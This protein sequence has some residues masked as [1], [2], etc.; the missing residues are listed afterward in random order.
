MDNAVYFFNSIAAIPMSIPPESCPHLFHYFF[1]LLSQPTQLMMDIKRR[2]EG[3]YSIMPNVAILGQEAKVS[4]SSSKRVFIPTIFIQADWVCRNHS[5]GPITSF[6]TV[7]L[8]RS[9]WK[10]SF[11]GSAGK[12]YRQRPTVMAKVTLLRVG[13]HG[14]SKQSWLLCNFFKAFVNR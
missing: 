12:R 7:P 8:T 10:G 14:G 3:E 2:Q 4:P 1:S 6:T 9:Q 13:V 5:L 11:S